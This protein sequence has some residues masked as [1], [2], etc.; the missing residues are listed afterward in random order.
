MLKHLTIM[1]G[2]LALGAAILPTDDEAKEPALGV[3]LT[4]GD[5]QQ[6]LD[7]G[8]AFELKIGEVTYQGK[9]EAAATRNFHRRGVSFDYPAGFSYDY[10]PTPEVTIFSVEGPD[11][12]VMLQV[13][14]IEMDAAELAQIVMD[15]TAAELGEL[16]VVSSE[17][18]IILG[19]KKLKGTELKV[20]LV[21]TSFVQ[22][23]FGL[24]LD[25]ET[26]VLFVQGGLDESGKLET[27]SS[28][29]IEL[30]TST[31]SYK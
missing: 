4:L 27:E 11:T 8:E 29:A 26:A 3:K 31:F 22:R 21:G 1:A 2:C 6:D 17:V 19:G 16:S 23:G 25:G 28:D 5:I 30:L 12:L 18:E 20:S 10:D 24:A 15:A 13:F 9:L 7:L 14:P